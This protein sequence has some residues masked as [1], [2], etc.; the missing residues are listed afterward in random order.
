MTMQFKLI[1]ALINEDTTTTVMDAA[2]QAGATGA[3]IISDA[4]GE[5]LKPRK[6]FFGLTVE[7]QCNVLLFIVEEHLSQQILAR[8]GEVAGFAETPGSGVAFCIAVEDTAGL[9]SQIASIME[10]K[11]T[12]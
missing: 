12:S 4:R 8:I 5:G 9:D 10:S 6:S 11:E 1:I 3:T 7:V 2:R